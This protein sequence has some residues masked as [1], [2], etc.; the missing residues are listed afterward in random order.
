MTNFRAYLNPGI[1]QALGAAYPNIH[2]YDPVNRK[3]LDFEGNPVT[4]DEERVQKYDLRLLNYPLIEEQLDM[5]YWDQV[6]GTT[7]WK[8]T[9]SQIKSERP[10]D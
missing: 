7:V 5:I 9:I 6:N 8:D 2:L 1:S 3:Y 10:I 4:I